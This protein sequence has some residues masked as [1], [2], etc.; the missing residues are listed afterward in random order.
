MTIPMA[1]QAEERTPFLFPFPDVSQG[2]LSLLPLGM[3][4][5][6]SWSQTFGKVPLV[7]SSPLAEASHVSS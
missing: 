2:C 3:T 7:D 5:A 1:N 6:D 4:S